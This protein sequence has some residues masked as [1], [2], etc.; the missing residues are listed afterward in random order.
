LQEAE[1]Q[2]LKKYYSQNIEE[3]DSLG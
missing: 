2:I 1:K 3:E